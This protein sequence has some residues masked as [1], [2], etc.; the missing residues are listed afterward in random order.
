MSTATYDRPLRAVPTPP[1]QRAQ[2]AFL[3]SARRRAHQV[4]DALLA[5]PRGAAGWALRHL[6][7]LL[8]GPTDHHLLGWAS[9]GLRG[10]ATLVR[11]IGLAPLAA[12][13]LSAP[14]V[15]RATVRLARASGSG[16]ATL[17]RAC[18][19]RA[20]GLLGRCGSPGGRIAKAL[21]STGSALTRA[22]QAVATHPAAQ[23]VIQAVRSV[24]SLVR[25]L[26]HGV[27][28]HRLLGLLVPA[29]WLRVALEILAVPLL[30]APGL[31][32]AIRSRLHE[33]SEVAPAGST[34][35]KPGTEQEATPAPSENGAEAEELPA[36]EWEQMLEPLNRAERRARQQDQARAK[37]AHARH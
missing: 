2:F 16:L 23:P 22:A 15:W 24:L 34:V 25:P 7:T 12:A 35:P 13:L 5:L 31:P 29:V 10:A 18:W 32:G 14:P 6:R 21:S 4:L 27:V 19:I 11:G 36:S 8:D 30:L 3:L 20:K 37:R 17:G 9:A 26:S 1:E 28:A 33:G